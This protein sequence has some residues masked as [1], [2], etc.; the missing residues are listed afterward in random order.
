MAQTSESPPILDSTQ[1]KRRPPKRYESNGD[2]VTKKQKTTSTMSIP[3]TALTAQP[4]T[5][6][7]GP[8]NN[9]KG[10]DHSGA[11]PS[12]PCTQPGADDSNDESHES[13]LEPIEV[14]DSDDEKVEVVEDDDEELGE[15]GIEF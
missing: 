2:L 3:S 8:R 7:T 1:C 15:R 5:S 6:S 11:S 14:S 12:P 10:N 13:N 9:K 4:S